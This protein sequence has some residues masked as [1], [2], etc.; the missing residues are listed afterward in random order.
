[1]IFVSFQPLS[2]TKD[3]TMTAEVGLIP[4][5]LGQGEYHM[6]QYG[7]ILAQALKD[8]ASNNV[9]LPSLLA[10]SYWRIRGRPEEAIKCLRPA[11]HFAPEDFK[12]FGLLA[13]ANIFHRSHRSVDAV[14]VLKEA[15]KVAPQ[16]PV[17]YLTLGNIYAT[18]MRFEE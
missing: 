1:M 4:S 14:Q 16:T 9:W 11:I 18:L 17:L 5:V 12:H 8:T 13:V 2:K 10:S 7:H 6:D 3:L 15:I